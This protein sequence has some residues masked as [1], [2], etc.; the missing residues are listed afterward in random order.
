MG[1]TLTESN[2]GERLSASRVAAIPELS[3]AEWSD[4]TESG[5]VCALVASLQPLGEKTPAQS[6]ESGVC[7]RGASAEGGPYLDTSLATSRHDSPER[8]VGSTLESI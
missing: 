6:P 4:Y 8:W 7:E 1:V 2:A 3:P 5:G